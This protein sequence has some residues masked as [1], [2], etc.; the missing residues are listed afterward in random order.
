MKE[1]SEGPSLLLFI[2]LVLLEIGS[3]FSIELTPDIIIFF[4]DT[5]SLTTIAATLIVIAAIYLFVNMPPSYYRPQNQYQATP[6]DTTINP[7]NASLLRSMLDKRKAQQSHNLQNNTPLINATSRTNHPTLKDAL[8]DFKRTFTELETSAPRVHSTISMKL[9]D[10]DLL[11]PITLDLIEDPIQI[12]SKENHSR[13]SNQFGRIRYFNTTKPTKEKQ[14]YER[15][16]LSQQP[17]SP[18][19]R[20]KITS[21]HCAKQPYAEALVSFLDKKVH[22]EKMLG[23]PNKLLQAFES[24]RCALEQNKIKTHHSPM[25]RHSS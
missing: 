21:R 23:A 4:I 18:M 11:C 12:T 19:T 22:I 10:T 5:L 17:L 14:Y 1:H 8:K 6:G 15:S 7:T 2:L 25:L 24:L 9:N 13:S 3:D 16:A 20:L